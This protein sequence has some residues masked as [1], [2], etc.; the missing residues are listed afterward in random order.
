M[1]DEQPARGFARAPAQRRDGA[2]T[3][4]MDVGIGHFL[5]FGAEIT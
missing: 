3:A 1:A 4:D 5:T 2:P